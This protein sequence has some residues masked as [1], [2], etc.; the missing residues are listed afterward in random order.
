[1]RT[2]RLGQLLSLSWGKGRAVCTAQ[3]PEPGPTHREDRWRVKGEKKQGATPESWTPLTEGPLGQPAPEC[4]THL[5]LS[6]LH[7]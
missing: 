5:P 6:P 7:G 2:V 3:C 1:M 4:S